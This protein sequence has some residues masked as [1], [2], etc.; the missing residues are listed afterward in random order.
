M[1]F[2]I[3]K[4]S[5]WG[6]A[7]FDCTYTCDIYGFAADGSSTV[8]GT[9]SLAD[10][11]DNLSSEGMHIS[12]DLNLGDVSYDSYGLVFNAYKSGSQSGGMAAS[13]TNLQ[14][15]G[16]MVPEPATASLGL[17]GLAA[18]LMRRRRV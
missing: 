7:E 3:A 8:I 18:M 1:S 12:I 4:S 14:I 2:D 5:T 11:V 9:W 13:I 10:A 15:S 17:I 16:E 6:S